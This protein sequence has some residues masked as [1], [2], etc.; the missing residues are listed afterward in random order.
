MRILKKILIALLLFIAVAYVGISYL[1]SNRVLIPASSSHENTIAD[2]PTYWNTT[3][4]AMMA[5]LPD[6]EP[7]S[8]SGFEGLSLKGQYFDVSDTNKCL[9]IFVHGWN[10]TWADML[11]YHPM[12]ADCRCDLLMYDHR[13]HGE[14]EGTYPTGGLKEAEDL[15]LVTEW[16]VRNKGLEKHQIAWLGS[17]WGAAT[18]IIAGAKDAGPAMIIADAPFQDWYSAVFERAIKDYGGGIRAIAPGVMKM[19]NLRAGIDYKEASPR[20]KAKDV[21][22][23]VLLIHSEGDL[24]TSSDQS[25]NIAANLNPASTFH[26]TQW[27]NGHVMDVVHNT[28]EMKKYLMDFIEKNSVEAFAPALAS[29]DTLSPDAPAVAY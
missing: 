1:L 16:V 13:V 19:V 25:A 18:S 10:M 15:L 9:F 28:E 8:I 14:S 21:K 5:P 6:P 11:K 22:A 2:I 26:H 23:P 4:E 7:V 24:A 3:F 27:G 12:V 20:E 17:S 29:V